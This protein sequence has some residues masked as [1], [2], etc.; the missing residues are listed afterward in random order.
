MVDNL[1][2][3]KKQKDILFQ[4]NI[5]VSWMELTSEKVDPMTLINNYT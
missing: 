2:Y 1:L 5:V 4:N 3:N